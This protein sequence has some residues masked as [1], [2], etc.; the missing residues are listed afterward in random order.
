MYWSTKWGWPST[1]ASNNKE[2]KQ[3]KY[4]C[5]RDTHTNHCCFTEQ[6]EYL[7]FVRNG[8]YI[9]RWWLYDKKV[10][11]LILDS[12]CE[13]PFFCWRTLLLFDVL[14]NDGDCKYVVI[15]YG[16]NMCFCCFWRVPCFCWP[17]DVFITFRICPFNKSDLF[18]ILNFYSNSQY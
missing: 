5:Q 14:L 6:K 12:V 1:N 8:K 2:D 11:Y 10:T 7:K 4:N 13:D 9:D 3:D 18:S 16:Y 15:I 17:F